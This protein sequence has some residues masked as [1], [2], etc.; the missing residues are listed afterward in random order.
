M[1]IKYY[2]GA[3]EIY[4]KKSLYDYINHLCLAALFLAKSKHGAQLQNWGA[5]H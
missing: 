3:L 5:R 2:S 4:I 1:I